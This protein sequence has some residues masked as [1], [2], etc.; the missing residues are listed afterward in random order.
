MSTNLKIILL[1][2]ILNTYNDIRLMKDV[3]EI[4]IYARRGICDYLHHLKIDQEFQKE[5]VLDLYRQLDG[6]RK[7]AITPNGVGIYFFYPPIITTI[8]TNCQIIDYDSLKQRI[9]LINKTI[10]SYK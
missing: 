7:I 6:I 2:K 10:R 8:D 9:E 1:N 5:I 4:P 3:K